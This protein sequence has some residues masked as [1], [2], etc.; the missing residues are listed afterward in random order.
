MTLV[1]VYNLIQVTDLDIE[2]TK[3]TGKSPSEDSGLGMGV[4][5][6]RQRY[7]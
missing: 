6:I 4:T 1:C 2:V 5:D 7:I 3:V